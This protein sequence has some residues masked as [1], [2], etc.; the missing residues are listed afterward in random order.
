MT[1]T[2]IAIAESV[3]APTSP[4][5]PRSG[6]LA[7]LFRRFGNAETLCV[8]AGDPTGDL[9]LPQLGAKAGP[10]ARALSA[11]RASSGV[12]RPARWPR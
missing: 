6:K 8:I 5:T 12:V 7:T 3:G 9:V 11:A 10:P 1:L 4:F 2:P